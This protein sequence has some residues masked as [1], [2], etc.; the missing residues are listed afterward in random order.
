MPKRI[1][2]I[3][4]NRDG[5]VGGS[6]FLLLDLIRGLDRSRYEPI[7][8]FHREN[9]LMDQFRAAG[10][11]VVLF[12]NLPPVDFGALNG[13]LMPIKKL[14]NLYRGLYAQA[15]VHAQ[16][17]REKRIDLVNLNN[18]M[19]RNH[20]WMLAARQVSIPCITHEMGINQSYSFLSRYF[21][22]RLDRI[23]SLSHAICKAMLENGGIA[24][25][26]IQVIH[27]G[28]DLT[29]YQIKETPA[30]LRQKHNIPEGAPVIGVVGNIR[31]W[32][33]Q[34][35]LIRATAI[36]K[37]KYPDI[38]CVLV[39]DRGKGP[40]EYG[41]RL[42]RIATELDVTGNMVL[43][44]FQ[45]NA[46]D[47]MELMDVVT[48]TSIHPEPF[49]IVT[50]EAM[51]RSK[52]LVSTTIGGPAEVV[53]NGESGLLVDPGKPAD[54]ANAIDRF[55]GD[56]E[57]ARLTGQR[58]YERMATHFSMQQSIDKTMAVYAEILRLPASQPA[59]SNQAVTASNI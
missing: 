28:I 54:L 31:E 32:K 30:Q 26:N 2:F 25:P 41:D 20:A 6:Y 37:K 56:P 50:L 49:G 34:E 57:Y 42:D 5:T 39:G 17:L 55:L 27:C 45:R 47:Y 38:R 44:G 35:T 3:E 48:H 7:V 11:E 21:G 36:L 22:K 18:S 58:G 51:S 8:G 15:R 33:G 12:D 10:A 46:I 4:S 19:T 16:Y 40:N 13:V 14:G 9:Y 24:F 29:R 53:V 52:P 43:A 23:I 1:L 59:A